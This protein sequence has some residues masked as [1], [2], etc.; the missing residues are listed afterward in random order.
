VFDF[1]QFV[2][3]FAY[4]FLGLQFTHLDEGILQQFVLDWNVMKHWPAT[5]WAVFIALILFLISI[6]VVL[7]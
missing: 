2:W 6:F 1:N 3:A 5:L 4:I 7:I